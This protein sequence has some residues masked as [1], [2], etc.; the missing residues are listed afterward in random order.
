LKWI[1]EYGTTKYPQPVVEHKFA[2]ERALRV[3]KEAL[4]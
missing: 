4:K 1:P 2:R 3:Y